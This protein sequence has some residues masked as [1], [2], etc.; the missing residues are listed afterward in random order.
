MGS[1][2]DYREI[3]VKIEAGKPIRVEA[4]PK[5]RERVG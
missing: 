2:Q 4:H 1:P 5:I 3:V